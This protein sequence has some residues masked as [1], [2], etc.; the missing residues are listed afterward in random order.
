VNLDAV[1]RLEP[2]TH[3]DGIL[4]LKDGSTVILSRTHREAFLQQ[5]GAAE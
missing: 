2:W 3:G 4:V 5:W 1:A